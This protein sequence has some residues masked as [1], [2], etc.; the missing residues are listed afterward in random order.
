[1]KWVYFC[2]QVF[3]SIKKEL[4]NLRWCYSFIF[5]LCMY[6]KAKLPVYTRTQQCQHCVCVCMCE[7][8]TLCS[9]FPRG[10]LS[11]C[12]NTCLVC[13][14]HLPS[15]PLLYHLSHFQSEADDSLTGA[16]GGRR[17]RVGMGILVF[18]TSE[19]NSWFLHIDFDFILGSQT[20]R[21]NGIEWSWC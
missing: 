18:H 6:R 14:A 5:V 20:S 1:M 8:S 21:R 16:K 17:T 7:H 11:E 2:S 15:G 12:E 10:C 19:V 4:I 3:Q 13:Y 9:C